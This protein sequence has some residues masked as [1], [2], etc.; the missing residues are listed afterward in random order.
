MQLG[1]DASVFKDKETCLAI[2]R[3]IVSPADERSLAD[4]DPDD[5]FDMTSVLLVKV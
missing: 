3:S 2:A 4:S 5:T 1:K